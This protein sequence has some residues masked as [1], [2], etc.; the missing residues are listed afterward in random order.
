MITCTRILEFDAGHR[1]FGHESKCSHAH[2]HRYKIEIEASAM[3]GLDSKGR[4]IDF[5]VL[6]GI[7]G[8]WID[9]NWDHGFIVN[10]EDPLKSLLIQIPHCVG[11][12]QKV[13]VMDENPTAENIAKHLG[14]K[15]CPDLLKNTDVTVTHIRIWETPNCYADWW[16][17]P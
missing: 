13:Y 15:V 16:L 12:L 2:G 10:N 8:T 6:K 14:S 4:V 17:E 7:V 3:S 5:S 11:G 9:E 1:V